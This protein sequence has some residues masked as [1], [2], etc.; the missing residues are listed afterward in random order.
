M[1]LAGD[2]ARKHSMGA[3][4]E[5]HS[6]KKKRLLKNSARSS[7]NV[8]PKLSPPRAEKS[9]EQRR[10]DEVKAYLMEEQP[11]KPDDKTPHIHETKGMIKDPSMLFDVYHQ[12]SQSPRRPPLKEEE[13][14]QHRQVYVSQL[15]DYITDQAHGKMENMQN[16]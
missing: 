5:D 2:E 1:I 4:K 13:E 7:L 9:L 11:K 16:K 15:E 12:H 14:Q 6:A 8:S 10:L 3:K